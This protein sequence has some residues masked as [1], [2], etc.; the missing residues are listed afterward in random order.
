[1]TPPGAPAA[2]TMDDMRSALVLAAVVLLSGC[3]GG[4]DDKEA[5]VQDASAICQ[6]AAAEK[7][8]LKAPAAPAD[9]APYAE[10]LV[11]IADRAQADL[12]ELEPPSEDRAELEEKVL[13]PFADV[14]NEGHAFADKVRRPAPTR[15]SC[16]R[17]CPRCRTPARSTSRTCA[18]T[19]SRPARTSSRRPDRSAAGRLT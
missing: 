14:V 13:D 5:Y 11:Q 15:R 12:A 3:G 17:C 9:F 6:K 1:M 7:A 2:G 19:A 4:G 18:P 16:C 8:E 10:G